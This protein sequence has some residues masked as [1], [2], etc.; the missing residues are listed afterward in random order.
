MNKIYTAREDFLEILKSK[1]YEFLNNKETLPLGLMF[2]GLG[3]SYAYDTFKKELRTIKNETTG[4]MELEEPSDVDFRAIAYNLKENILFLKDYE[5]EQVVTPEDIDTT[6]YY[7]NKYAKLLYT[8]NPNILEMMGLPDKKI[9]IASPEYKLLKDN[10]DIFLTTRV[11]Y[12]FGRY[13]ED[14]LQRLENALARDRLPQSKKEQHILKSVLRQ[15]EDLMEKGAMM[16][17]LD[18]DFK[19]YIDASLKEDMDSEI[20]VDAKFSHMPLR[21]VATWLGSMNHV[22]NSYDKLNKR[23]R[24]KSEQK[25]SKHAMHL[26]RLIRMCIEILTGKGIITSR[27]EAGDID[28]MMDIRNEKI[29]VLE[30]AENAPKLMKELEYAFR[31]S[32]LPEKVDEKRAKEVIMTIN[33][34][35]LERYKQ[36]V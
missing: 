28:R 30:V 36:R 31:N 18:E 9:F 3:G 24:K 35:T 16:L 23:N 5:I 1:E 6:I 27:E 22:V 12:T 4:L 21:D 10:I 2:L 8:Q 26:E 11:F 19:L 34:M 20:F 13:A 32:V 29:P 14:Q 33:E 17:K 25:L 15:I 7:L